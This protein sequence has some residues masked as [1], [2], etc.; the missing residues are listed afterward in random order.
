LKL[1]SD[2]VFHLFLFSPILCFKTGTQ[3]QGYS[4]KTCFVVS[5]TKKKKNLFPN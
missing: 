3:T 2:F 4:D 5:E 1:F